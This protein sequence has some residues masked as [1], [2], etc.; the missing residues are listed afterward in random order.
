MAKCIERQLAEPIAIPSAGTSGTQARCGSPKPD[1]PPFLAFTQQF[2][3]LGVGNGP[4]GR[5]ERIK[6]NHPISLCRDLRPIIDTPMSPP[7]EDRGPAYEQ[8]IP[9]CSY[10]SDSVSV[11]AVANHFDGV[12]FSENS[13]LAGCSDCVVCGK[14]A[15]QIQNEAVNDYL[16][17]TVV[18]GETLAET[19]RRKSLS[20]RDVDRHIF[21]HARG[22]VAGGRLRWKLV[23]NRVWLLQ[24]LTRNNSTR[25]KKDRQIG[26]EVPSKHD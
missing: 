14:T 5:D 7:S 8:K 25:L 23:H 10:S 12:A 1:F 21:A 15:Q 19:E 2:F 17:K 13:V 26:T 16:D 20:G 4:I 18:P 11:E 22:S 9:S 24:S 3:D 6:S